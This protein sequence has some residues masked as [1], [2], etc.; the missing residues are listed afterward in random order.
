MFPWLVFYNERLL[1]RQNQDGSYCLPEDE[2]I[3]SLGLDLDD[4]KK[5]WIKSGEPGHT[6][7]LQNEV[8]L[9]EGWRFV[10]LLYLFSSGQK[11]LFRQAGRAVQIIALSKTHRYCGQCGA[12]TEEKADEFV[13]ICNECGL[14]AYPRISPSIIVAVTKGRELLLVRSKHFKDYIYHTIVSGF[15]EPG[16]TL[17]ECV[18]REVMEETG[19]A[20]KNIRYFGSQPWPFPN[21]L[22]LGFTAEYD[23]GDIEVDDEELYEANWY[24]VDGLPH[25]PTSDSIASELIEWFIKNNSK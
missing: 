19:V 18:E 5:F 7:E 17:E 1:L 4:H 10:S 20:V 6:V 9:P 11:S 15:V 13:K 21:S 3:T 12:P 14:T 16:E 25:L 24:A 2:S 23:Y 22:M 8:L